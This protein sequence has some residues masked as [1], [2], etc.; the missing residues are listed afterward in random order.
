MGQEAV[1]EQVGYYLCFMLMIKF[2]HFIPLVSFGFAQ[3]FI[4][5]SS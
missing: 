2:L 5:S 1:N 4:N 3:D